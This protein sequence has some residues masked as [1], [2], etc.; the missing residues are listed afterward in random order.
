MMRVGA[1]LWATAWGYL[2]ASGTGEV[3]SVPLAWLWGAAALSFLA[4]WGRMAERVYVAGAIWPF[5][6]P[7]HAPL[8]VMLT[9]SIATLF[10]GIAIAARIL[11]SCIE[12]RGA[13]AEWRDAWLHDADEEPVYARSGA[14]LNLAAWR[15]LTPEAFEE[16][17][18][19]LF[20]AHGYRGHLTALSGDEGIDL[21]LWGEGRYIVVQCKRYLQPI[22]QPPLRDF[23]GAMRAA[24]ADAGYFITT[25]GFSD[26]AV[27]W[28]A[29]LEDPPLYLIDGPM[30]AHWAREG[31]L[32]DPC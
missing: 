16:E 4:A 18:L 31:R 15:C 10:Q 23:A 25:S 1:L 24:G 14:P 22:G 6:F 17:V 11:R 13:R 27:R 29:A 7:A 20:R 26:P 21:E 12:W 2:L 3:A 8:L 30:L 19:E 5:F 28:A 9:L 32:P